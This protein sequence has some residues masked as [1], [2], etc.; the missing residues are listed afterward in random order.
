[1]T[2][3][4]L[5]RVYNH[6]I[7][8]PRRGGSDLNLHTYGRRLWGLSLRFVH[9]SPWWRPVSFPILVVDIFLRPAVV[10]LRRR[11]LIHVRV[12]IRFI[13]DRCW[14][15]VVAHVRT[16]L[17]IVASHANDFILRLSIAIVVVDW[18]RRPPRIV[19]AVV[20]RWREMVCTVLYR[21]IVARC[22][23]GWWVEVLGRYMVD[24]VFPRIGRFVCT[25][26]LGSGLGCLCFVD[27]ATLFFVSASLR[28][29][30]ARSATVGVLSSGNAHVA[31][32]AGRHPVFVRPVPTALRARPTRR[33]YGVRCWDVAA[34]WRSLVSGLIR[35]RRRRLLGW[36][37]WSSLSLRFTWRWR[38]GRWRCVTTIVFALVS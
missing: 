31:V 2:L 12:V 34:I 9:S 35:D 37:Q 3:V 27:T 17:A 25:V 20:A 8:N 6:S 30:N 15:T 24:T 10:S 22:W 33:P 14:L 28:S 16:G 32:V 5:T 11:A 36:G 4:N 29:S 7:L 18:R 13:A 38:I 23:S 1:M 26:S 21:H 19:V